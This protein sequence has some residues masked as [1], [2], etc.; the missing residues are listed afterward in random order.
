MGGPNYAE[1]E[2]GC[3]TDYQRQGYERMGDSSRELWNGP[4]RNRPGQACINTGPRR[5]TVRVLLRRARAERRAGGR[6]EWQ[7]GAPGAGGAAGRV[8]RADPG[9]GAVA[10]RRMT[11]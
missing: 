5:R 11:R 1:R 6:G 10:M 2:R 3:I 7:P 4:G 9:S 8:A